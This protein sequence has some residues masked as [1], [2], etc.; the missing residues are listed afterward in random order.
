MDVIG[1]A[2]AGARVYAEP[3]LPEL[4]AP[5]FRVMDWI[6]DEDEDGNPL[7]LPGWRVHVRRGYNLNAVIHN[8]LLHKLRGDG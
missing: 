4:P 1:M 3:F 6:C 7:P 5:E 2:L 8:R